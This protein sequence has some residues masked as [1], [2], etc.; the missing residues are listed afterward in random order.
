[1]SCYLCC[2]T[3]CKENGPAPKSEAGRL[4]RETIDL[5]LIHQRGQLLQLL[6]GDA[7][8]EKADGVLDAVL[9]GLQHLHN[10]GEQMELPGCEPKLCN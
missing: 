7:F 10:I 5:L 2:G 6:R 8:G 1:M 9:E 3:Q 4:Q